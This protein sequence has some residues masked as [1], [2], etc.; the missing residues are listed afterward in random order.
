MVSGS[1]GPFE[2]I[3]YWSEIKL[4]ILREY[5]AAY[6]LIFSAPGQRQLHHVYIDAFAGA[7]THISRTSRELVPGSPLNALQIEP[8]F[9][10]FYLI[11]LDGQ[12]ADALRQAVGERRD[13]HI[14]QGDCNPILLEQVFPQV[15]YENYRR[16]LCLLDPYGLHLNWEVIEAAGKSKAIDMFLN[17]PVMDMNR[18]VLWQEPVRVSPTQVARMNAF[19]GD[20]TWRAVLYS[21]QPDLFGEVH[22]QKTGGANRALAAAFQRRLR[23]VAGFRFVPEPIPMRNS[24]GATVYY[25]YFGSQNSIGDHITRDIFRKYRDRGAQ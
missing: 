4:N 1:G 7:G 14:Y 12:K 8:P 21:Q 10:E 5:A 24:Q 9:R 13:V 16:G 25:L 19:W 23:D 3:G 2:S 20:E 18:N 15:R 17:F 22:D 11:D 6:S